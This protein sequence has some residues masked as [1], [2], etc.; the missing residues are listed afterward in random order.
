MFLLSVIARHSNS[1]SSK[2]QRRLSLV[3]LI[4]RCLVWFLV[5]IYKQALSTNDH[6][7]FVPGPIRR[8]LRCALPFVLSLQHAL[9]FIIGGTSLFCK[10]GFNLKSSWQ[11][12]EDKNNYT[13][14]R[15]VCEELKRKGRN[16]RYNIQFPFERITQLQTQLYIHW[17]ESIS[18]RKT[19]TVNQIDVI[20]QCR[21]AIEIPKHVHAFTVQHQS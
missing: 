7:H 2:V 3:R 9:E 8:L 15:I 17:V 12:T 16:L 19:W 4:R 21:N 11:T 14:W 20:K 1:R 13:T 5:G 10:I 18:S 6:V